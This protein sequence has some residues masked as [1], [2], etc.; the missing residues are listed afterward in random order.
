MQRKQGF[1]LVEMLI[2]VLI[3]G[4]LAAA[5]LPRI[6]GHLA[7]TR[8]VK[9]Q[10][11]LRNIAAA[12]ELY[13]DAKWTFPTRGWRAWPHHTRGTFQASSFPPCFTFE[14]EMKEYLSSMPQDPSRSSLVKLHKEA[15]NADKSPTTLYGS[16]QIGN[17]TSFNCEGKQVFA[18]KF[19]WAVQPGQYFYQIFKKGGN[20]MGAAILAAKVETPELANYIRFKEDE[21]LRWGFFSPNRVKQIA[22]QWESQIAHDI[23]D[24]KLCSSLEKVVSGNEAFDIQSD[25]TV[26]CK[27]SNEEQLYYIVKIE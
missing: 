15:Q 16:Y 21:D 17:T 5:I 19:G 27:F 22:G 4:I 26:R 20:Q 6:T 10:L 3:I 2:V 18:A 7:K 12:I 13:R 9:R 25:G 11:D 1:T 14:R 8:D 24:L 23:E